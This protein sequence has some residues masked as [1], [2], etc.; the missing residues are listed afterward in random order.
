MFQNIMAFVTV[1]DTK[2]FRNSILVWKRIYFQM[3][4]YVLI[5]LVHIFG[6]T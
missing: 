4:S 3:Q 5:E 2:D 1:E 6:Q